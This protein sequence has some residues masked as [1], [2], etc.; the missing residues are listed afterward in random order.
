M[1]RER[2][3]GVTELG[4]EEEKHDDG[5]GEGDNTTGEGSTVE[6]L[7]NLRVCVQCTNFAY[8]IIHSI[9]HRLPPKAVEGVSSSSSSMSC[10]N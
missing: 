10:G 4:D 6:I 5:G 9:C 8:Y 1:Q 7:I 3:R 2:E